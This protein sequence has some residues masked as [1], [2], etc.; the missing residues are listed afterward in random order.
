M[1]NRSQIS[2]QS[3]GVPSLWVRKPA[4]NN[5]KIVVK[6]G[7]VGKYTDLKD[8]Y[9]SLSE[10]IVHGGLSNKAEVDIN[11][12]NSEKLSPKEILHQIK[13][14]QGILIPGGFGDRGI[15]GMIIS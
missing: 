2:T 10:A 12:I 14:D 8:S 6:I 1:K 7:V 13:K 4:E 9:K 3:S 5:P 11:W 15:E